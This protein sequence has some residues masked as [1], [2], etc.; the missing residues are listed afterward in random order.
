MQL[1][2]APAIQMDFATTIYASQAHTRAKRIRPGI[3]HLPFQPA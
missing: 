1:I 3:R 2:P